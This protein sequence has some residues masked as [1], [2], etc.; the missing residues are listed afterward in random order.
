[1]DTTTVNY[2]IAKLNEAFQAIK[3]TAVE[4]GSEYIEYIV[5]K[6]TLTPIFT[7]IVFVIALGLLITSIIRVVK[8]DGG[9]GAFAM[10]VVGGVAS[11]FSGVITIVDSYYAILANIYPLMY[12]IEQLAK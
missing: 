11:I 10:M 1:M 3:P 5:L 6:A 12:T 2:A 7:G 8:Y 9:D 4:L